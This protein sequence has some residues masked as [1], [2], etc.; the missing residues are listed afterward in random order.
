MSYLDRLK[1]KFPEN[2]PTEVLTK[3]TEAPFVSSVSTRVGQNKAHDPAEQSPRDLAHRG[4]YLDRLKD[5][6]PENCP[7]EVLTKPT[8]APFVSS[9]STRV[10]QNKPVEALRVSA[11]IPQKPDLPGVSPEFAARLSAEDLEDIAA[12][13]IPLGTLQAFESA[14]VTREAEDLREHFEE[15]AGILEF[16]AGLP[17]A[18]V[19]LEAARITA[20]YARNRGY[21]W[22]SLRAALAG[23]PLLLSQVPDTP[24]TVDSL[25]LGAATAHVC[26]GDKPGPVSGTIVITEAEIEAARKGR[27][28]GASPRCAGQSAGRAGMTGRS[29]TGTGSSP[30]DFKSGRESFENNRIP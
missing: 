8:E 30:R 6:F 22:A 20:T 19:E 21:L 23:Y 2:C 1:D 7:T 10:G 17:R 14:A 13:D 4:G 11:G 5:K 26:E 16:D 24:G 18:D 28:C 9:V 25:P 29:R 27:T 3:P 15:R 12:G